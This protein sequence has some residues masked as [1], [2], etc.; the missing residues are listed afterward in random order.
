MGLLD[1]VFQAQVIEFP[2]KCLLEL[3]LVQTSVQT[4][5]V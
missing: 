1:L 4:Q 2:V 5:I 3:I